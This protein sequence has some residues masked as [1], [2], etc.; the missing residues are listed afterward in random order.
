MAA[1]E[2][3]FAGLKRL[4]ADEHV[5]HLVSEFQITDALVILI[6]DPLEHVADGMNS[7]APCPQRAAAAYIEN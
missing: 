5:W 2:D 4:G 3:R 1:G 7:L 6:G